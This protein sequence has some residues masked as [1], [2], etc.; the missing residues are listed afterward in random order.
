MGKSKKIGKGRKDPYY[1]KAKE[2]NYRA[3]SSFKLIQLN[4]RFNFLTDS[5][6]LV[7]LCAAPGG[8]LQV[9]AEHMPTKSL[10]LGVDL[11]PIKPIRGCITWQDD[12][13]K[14]SCVK[15]IK[16]YL[17]TIKADCFLHDGAPNV[18]KNRLHDYY[19]QNVLALH[20]M[21]VACIFLRKG[22]TFVT[23]VFRSKDYDKLQWV[24]R[25]LFHNVHAT[26]PKASRDV[27]SEIFVVCQKFKFSSIKEIDRQFFDPKCVF[28]EVADKEK[29]IQLRDFEPKKRKAKGYGDELQAVIYNEATAEEFLQSDSP[30]VFL[31]KPNL[32]IVV[33]ESNLEKLKLDHDMVECLKDVGQCSKKDIKTLLKWHTKMRKQLG[34]VVDDAEEE[35]QE[36]EEELDSDTEM[37]KQLQKIEEEEARDFKQKRR[38][39]RKAK[40]KAR[41]RNLKNTTHLIVDDNEMFNLQDVKTKSKLNKLDTGTMD[42]ES[43]DEEDDHSADE[44]TESSDEESSDE[45][46]S[47]MECEEN[48]LLVGETEKAPLWFQDKL[49][50]DIEEEGEAD[51]VM[52]G[53]KYYQHKKEQLKEEREKAASLK[54]DEVVVEQKENVPPNNG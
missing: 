48:P 32:K 42:D 43:S 2:L 11:C 25:Q 46:C 27:S 12:I 29:P 14:Q 30:M 24:M 50:E 47:D 33:D 15:Q 45:E 40:E 8:W 4:R 31:H 35:D 53:D 23:K 34:I 41:Q 28:E 51:D 10:I 16:D 52:Q 44:E 26:K 5:K 21:K 36:E 17:I 20:A 13:T 37:E 9:A 6:I 49:F 38:A 18:G 3:R 19:N 54:D 1:F 39:V 7:D 22:G